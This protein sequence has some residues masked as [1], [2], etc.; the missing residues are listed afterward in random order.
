MD[1]F[2]R[3]VIIITKNEIGKKESHNCN[4]DDT[5]DDEDCASTVL[6]WW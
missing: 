6:T 2:T 4:F 5:K 3:K 1:N